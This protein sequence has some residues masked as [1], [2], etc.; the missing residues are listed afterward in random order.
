M[1]GFS[2][3][4]YPPRKHRQFF[5]TFTLC[6]GTTPFE[7][8]FENPFLQKKFSTF[9][10]D[11]EPIIKT[12]KI[13]HFFSFLPRRSSP[14]LSPFYFQ[15]CLLLIKKMRN[16]ARLASRTKSIIIQFSKKRRP[17]DFC[18]DFPSFYLVKW[19]K[20]NEKHAKGH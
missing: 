7:N 11:F 14:A 10:R 12:H 1:V 20:S 4:Y 8:P 16:F 17:N 13:T 18:L 3:R 5:Q 6:S 19:S 9:F 15:K 2:L